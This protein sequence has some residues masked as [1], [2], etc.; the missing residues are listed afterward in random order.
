MDLLPLECPT[1]GAPARP[2]GA[3]FRVRTPR[4]EQVAK[5]WTVNILANSL[6]RKFVTVLSPSH[7]KI[8]TQRHISANHVHWPQPAL[9]LAMQPQSHTRK[10]DGFLADWVL[11]S[12]GG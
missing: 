1:E 4:P 6:H 11:K 3:A 9:S 12:C 8:L 5:V 7:P 10:K 2:S